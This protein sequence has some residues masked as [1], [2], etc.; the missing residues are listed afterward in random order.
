MKNDHPQLYYHWLQKFS[1]HEATGIH[2]H[3]SFQETLFTSASPHLHSR[4]REAYSRVSPRENM[5][6][7]MF[8][9]LSLIEIKYQDLDIMDKATK[10]SVNLRFFIL[11]GKSL[12]K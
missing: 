8:C 3:S 2:W 6:L 4:A 11:S 12:V 10:K 1:K 9:N 5:L 7:K